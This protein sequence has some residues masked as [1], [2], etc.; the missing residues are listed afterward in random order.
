MTLDLR[1]STRLGAPGQ[2]CTGTERILSPLPLLL[3]YGSERSAERG[4]RNGERGRTGTVIICRSAFRV[5]HSALDWCRMKD[6]NLQPS[7]SERDASPNW[8]NA[9]GLV[10]SCRLQVAGWRVTASAALN[11]HPTTFNLQLRVVLPA[12]I[13]PAISAFEARRSGA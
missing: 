1:H 4:A 2:G 9:A 5:P 12:G 10:A 8:A 3:G 13:S 11:L 7:R 6:S